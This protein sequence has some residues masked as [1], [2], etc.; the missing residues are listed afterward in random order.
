MYG[1]IR[2]DVVMNAV[3]WLKEHNEYYKD[4]ELNDMW[5]EEWM[6]TELGVVFGRK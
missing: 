5:D 2:K 3:K 6:A 4:I 1:H